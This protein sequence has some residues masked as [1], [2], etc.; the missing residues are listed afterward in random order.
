MKF[1]T[2]IG[3]RLGIY[4]QIGFY[5]FDGFKYYCNNDRF[6][7]PT[8]ANSKTTLFLNYIKRK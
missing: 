8:T 2:Q 4:T 1:I 3:G 5:T 7:A 6:S